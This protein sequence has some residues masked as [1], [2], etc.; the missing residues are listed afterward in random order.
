MSPGIEPATPTVAEATTLLVAIKISRKSWVAGIKSPQSEKIG[1]HTLGAADVAGLKG[2]VEER[3]SRA[4]RA[5]GRPWTCGCATRPSTRGFGWHAG[6]SRRW[7]PR[8]SCSIRR[9]CW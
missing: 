7:R 4:E 2:L 9:V 6:W 8:R 5:F 3:R 1:L